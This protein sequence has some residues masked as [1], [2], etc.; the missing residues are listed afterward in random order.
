M[1]IIEQWKGM[2]NFSVWFPEAWDKVKTSILKIASKELSRYR[3]CTVEELSEEWVRLI[4]EKRGGETDAIELGTDELHEMSA[5]YLADALRRMKRFPSNSERTLLQLVFSE[6]K[7]NGKWPYSRDMSVNA[8]NIGLRNYYEMGEKIGSDY[9][10]VGEDRVAGATSRLTIRAIALCEGAGNE[11]RIFLMILSVFVEQYNANPRQPTVNLRDLEGSGDLTHDQS[12]MVSFMLQEEDQ[13]WTGLAG[14]DGKRVTFEVTP[15][16]LKFEGVKTIREYLRVLDTS[17]KGE[18]SIK[19]DRIFATSTETSE[20][21]RE[22]E[23]EFDLFISYSSKDQTEADDICAKC[24]AAG[25]ITFL[26]PK[27]IDSGYIGP[28]KIKEALKNSSEMTILMSPNSITSEWVLTEWGA[29]WILEKH[30]TPILLNC[31]IGDVPKLLQD[32][33]KRD[34]PK[35]LERFIKEVLKR[36]HEA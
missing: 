16:I 9:I 29:A 15:S 1:E 30:V 8:S 35:E 21:Y 2:P 31:K 25:I 26:A 23:F 11:L 4:L 24:E 28:E 13:L 19:E 17:I 7:Q 12:Q 33:Q 18:E 36:K 14:Y 6:F 10:R 3:K 20:S 22:K 32:R 27:D 5:K 34:Y